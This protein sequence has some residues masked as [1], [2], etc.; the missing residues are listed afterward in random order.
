VVSGG[1]TILETDLLAALL[2]DDR[3]PDD[4]FWG[5]PL[6]SSWSTRPGSACMLAAW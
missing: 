4:E 2:A 5:G 3:H 1:E 6:V